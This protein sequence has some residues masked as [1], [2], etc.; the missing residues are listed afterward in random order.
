MHF[1]LVIST[2]QLS[3]MASSGFQT[4][5]SPWACSSSCTDTLLLCSAPDWQSLTMYNPI[6]LGLYPRTSWLF[7]NVWLHLPSA[8]QSTQNS[9]GS[10]TFPETTKW[11]IP[12]IPPS[13]QEMDSG[14][15]DPYIFLLFST[16][17]TPLVIC[18]F[19]QCERLVRASVFRSEERYCRL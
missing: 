15:K 6:L 8:Q 7:F 11:K 9:P 19:H 14:P 13:M 12:P 5:D 18:N 3:S 1:A 17:F 2:P 16:I 10:R 4:S